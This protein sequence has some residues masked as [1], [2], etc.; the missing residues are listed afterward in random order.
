LREGK[1]LYGRVV[2]RVGGGAI[3][4]ARIAVEGEMLGD[5]I[6]LSS[7]T[8]SGADGSFTLDGL[9]P[10]RHS[11]D[12]GADGHDSR[13]VSGLEVPVD[14]A[15]GPITIDLGRVEPGAEPKRELVGIGIVIAVDGS[16]AHILIKQAVPGGGAAAAGLGAGDAILAV[17]G[18]SVDEL[19]FPVAVQNIRGVEGSLVTLT[20]RRHDGSIQVVPVV[21]KRI[22]S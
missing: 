6:T 13:I 12:V 4:G 20:V 15:L 10:G 11:I 17:D 19:T 22:S 16:G 1:R 9:A 21:R 7:D 5:G 3:A 18:T 8:Q 14:G 2:E